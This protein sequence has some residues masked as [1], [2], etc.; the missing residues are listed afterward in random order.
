MLMYVCMCVYIRPIHFRDKQYIHTTGYAPN[1]ILS[2]PAISMSA[3]RE[4]A[5]E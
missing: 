2:G 4:V 5:L 1:M 3:R